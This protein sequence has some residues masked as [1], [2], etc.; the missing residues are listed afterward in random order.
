MKHFIITRFNLKNENWKSNNSNTPKGISESWLTNRL[1]LFQKFCLPSVKN[2]SNQNF[3]WII[4]IDIDT[5]IFF[6]NKINEILKNIEN[7]KLIYV[8]GFNGLSSELNTKIQSLLN[9]EDHFIITT[10]LDNDDIIHRDFVK[11]IQELYTPSHNT[12]IDLKN[13]YQLSLNNS[14]DIRYLGYAFNPFISL[15]EASDNIKTVLFKEHISWRFNCEKHIIYIT[16]RLWIQLI[17]SKNQ[18]N[19]TTRYLKRMRTFDSEEFGINIH[20][21][22]YSNF[23]NVI[24]NFKILPYRLYGAIFMFF[25]LRINK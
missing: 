5:P 24:Y 6:K 25:K 4:A 14:K 7:I 13:G 15:I 22:T 16:K 12:I 2:Q 11:T 19:T 20:T 23:E 17:H 1:Q 10:R 9:P 8:D 21:T 18:A 3:I